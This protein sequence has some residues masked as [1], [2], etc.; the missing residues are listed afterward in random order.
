M[1]LANVSAWYNVEYDCAEA[2]EKE[3]FIGLTV[4]S[5]ILLL[6]FFYCLCKDFILAAITKYK[7]C[8]QLCTD[9]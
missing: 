8:C 9:N 5:V 4:L 6:I 1:D 2:S 7:L 3:L